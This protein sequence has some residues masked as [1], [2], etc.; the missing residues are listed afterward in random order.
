MKA[1]VSMVFFCGLMLFATQA[2]AEGAP[3]S[4]FRGPNGAGLAE[5][6]EIPAN[7]SLRDCKWRVKLPGVG[8]SS[9]VVNGDRV[10][11][12]CGLE[13]NGEQILRC[14]RTSDGGLIWK[15]RF[16]GALY[17]KHK[18]NSYASSTPA[19][20][21]DSL[22]FAYATPEKY[23]L[24]KLDQARGQEVWRRDF[25]PFLSQ[26]G[27]GASPIV[28]E[29]MVIVANEQDGPSSVIAVDRQTG[30]TRWEAKRRTEKAAFATPCIFQ[31]QG[32]PPQLLVNS[33]AHGFSSLDPH[34][35][36]LNWELP[37]FHYRVVGSP[38]VVGDLVFGSCGVGGVGRQMF[39]VRPGNPAEGTPAEVVYEIKGSLPYVCTPVARD[40]LLFSW[41][42]RGVVTCL[43]AP[44]GKVLWQE[45][46]GGDYF[47][48]PVRVGDRLYC[49]SRSGQMVVLAAAAEFREIARIDLEEP[50]HATPAVADGVMYV[51][52]VSHLMAIG[53]D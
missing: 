53:G 2:G 51:R 47:C 29:D 26:H 49:V 24:V 48:S 23:M 28:F 17:S 20:D 1:L 6:A 43:D 44:T 22:Y 39:A 21:A 10:F 16:E 40:D 41:F 38:M 50:T 34:T 46:I 18:F 13:E 8:H 7:W 4:R 52:T 45:R 37:I 15:R 5:K 11:V 19:L 33:W 27:F 30:Q 31:R 25:G 3:W 32:Q 9:P 36:R 35:G 12:S 14:L 42:D